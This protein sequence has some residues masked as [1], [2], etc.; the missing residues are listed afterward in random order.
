MK[1]FEKSSG[2]HGVGHGLNKKEKACGYSYKSTIVIKTESWEFYQRKENPL[3][4]LWATLYTDRYNKGVVSSENN[5]SEI[6]R[7]LNSDDYFQ[8][9]KNKEQLKASPLDDRFENTIY[10]KNVRAFK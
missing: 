5:F 9:C 8:I 3:T 4:L 2:H 10:G 6:T 1:C 7:V